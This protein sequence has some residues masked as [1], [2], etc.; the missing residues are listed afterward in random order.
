VERTKLLTHI[1]QQAI[2]IGEKGTRFL[3]MDHQQMALVIE[4]ATNLRNGNTDL[5]LNDKSKELTAQITL[6]QSQVEFDKVTIERYDY[7]L[8]FQL[9]ASCFHHFVLMFWSFSTTGLN[10]KFSF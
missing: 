1:R 5:P 2:D 10:E 6:L 3:G 7:C 8:S 9:E 4:F